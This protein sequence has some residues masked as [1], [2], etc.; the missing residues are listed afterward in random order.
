MKD[1][2]LRSALLLF[3]GVALS[4]CGD[5]DPTNLDT[6]G[7]PSDV[8][9]RAYVEVNGN[10]TFDAGIDQA[11]SGTTI[12]LESTLTDNVLTAETDATGLATFSDVPSGVYNAV[13]DTTDL[14]EGLTDVAIAEPG[15]EQS[16]VTPFAGDTTG[17][18][19]TFEF[20]YMPAIIQ[21]TVFVDVNRSGSYEAD[22]DETPAPGVALNLYAGEGV[23][24]DP[25]QTG[26]TDDLGEYSFMVY[27]GTYTLDVVPGEQSEVVLGDVFE[28]TLAAAD[29]A[30][31][32]SLVRTAILTIAEAE[33]QP[34]STVVLVDGVV[35]VEPGNIS[36]SY[37]W[38]QDATG[39]VKVFTGATT[40]YIVGD[41]LRVTGRIVTSFGEKII[42]SIEIEDLGSAPVPTPVEV[43]G[44]AFLRREHQGELVTIDS[45]LIDSIGTGGSY[46]VYVS[47]P[48]TSEIF[49]IRVDSD[50]GIGSGVFTVGQYYRVSGVSSPFSG[51]EQL[52]PRSMGDIIPLGGGVLAIAS[53]RSIEDSTVVTVRGVVHTATDNISGS[54][55]FMHDRTAGVKV[56]L[57]GTTANTNWLAG[58]SL[59]V[60]GEKVTRFGEVQ[61]EATSITDIGNGTVRAPI[62]V[63]GDELLTAQTQG[64]L[65]TVPTVTVDVVGTGTSY[66]VEVTDPETGAEFII[67]VDSDAGITAGTFVV[68][69][70][71]TVTGVSSPFGGAEQLYPRSNADIVA[72]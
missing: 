31:L 38:I 44:A 45:L 64:N 36:G 5:D 63:D 37:F 25:V 46:N 41:S 71:Y 11:L 13:I 67:R 55:F 62:V 35:S 8:S 23:S 2:L 56:F 33:A 34:D 18:E 57:A 61:I 58:D 65:V 50:A 72:H 53:A 3:V 20:R 39:G 1:T 6:L 59:E 28:M 12:T 17:V 21:G 47:A 51:E 16:V 49:I 4:A 32:T 29:T 27:P 10:D 9:V 60:T 7:T 26:E 30:D 19:A 68:G 15:L 52:Y 40:S 43:T 24:G 14:P 42:N 70:S 66:N 69:R 22:I 48:D 54:Y